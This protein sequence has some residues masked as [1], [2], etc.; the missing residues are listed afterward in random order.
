MRRAMAPRVPYPGLPDGDELAG[1]LVER[2]L[3]GIAPPGGT[4]PPARRVRPRGAGDGSTSARRAG[5]ARGS[6]GDR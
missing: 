2:L 4:K 5:R 1:L 3:H 6:S